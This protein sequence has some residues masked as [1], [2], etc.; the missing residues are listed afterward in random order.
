MDYVILGFDT[1]HLKQVV[2]LNRSMPLLCQ[3][4]I[5]PYL[6]LFHFQHAEYFFLLPFQGGIFLAQSLYVPYQQV[7]QNGYDQEQYH[8]QYAEIFQGGIAGNEHTGHVRCHAHTAQHIGYTLEVGN[9]GEHHVDRQQGHV[10]YD[11]HE[12]VLGR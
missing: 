10:A 6:L 5:S 7:P 11:K 3:P 8:I 9:Q 2:R 4:D 1:Q 12:P